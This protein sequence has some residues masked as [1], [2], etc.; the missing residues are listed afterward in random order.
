M[1]PGMMRKRSLR[2][3]KRELFFMHKGFL[4][5]P[6]MRAHE[7]D[8]GEGK[9]PPHP[10]QTNAPPPHHDGGCDEECGSLPMAFAHPPQRLFAGAGEDGAPEHEDRFGGFEPQQHR[11]LGNMR[12]AEQPEQPEAEAPPAGQQ[13]KA[14][15]P[16]MAAMIARVKKALPKN[17]YNNP[18]GFTVQQTLKFQ[19]G[20][21]PQ[22]TS[23]AT[24]NG[25]GTAGKMQQANALPLPPPAPVLR[26][27]IMRIRAKKEG[28]GGPA[29]QAGEPSRD[30]IDKKVIE[31]LIKDKAK[32]KAQAKKQ[33][34]QLQQLKEKTGGASGGEAGKEKPEGGDKPE[35]GA[36]SEGGEKHGEKHGEHKE[37]EKEKEKDKGGEPKEETSISTT[38]TKTGAEGEE[39]H[40]KHEKEEKH[41]EHGEHGA[42]KHGEHAGHGGHG[43][44]KHRVHARSFWRRAAAPEPEAWADPEAEAWAEAEAEA[45]ADAYPEADAHADAYPEAYPEADPEA[46]ADAEGFYDDE[47]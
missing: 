19:P 36:K 7:H 11:A 34:K 5:P 6:L 30:A 18:S 9:Q 35:G 28:E 31:K 33:K 40:E 42:G 8:G 47:Y 14:S 27:L 21:D 38:T 22:E 16:G 13:V 20:S 43:L 1:S 24:P 4:P 44:D 23:E 25:G 37:G 10:D 45:Y 2:P 17:L 29:E 46:W 39:K 12:L 15:D 3:S 32:L 41:D 26:A